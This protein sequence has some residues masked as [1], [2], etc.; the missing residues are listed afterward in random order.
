MDASIT[1]FVLNL[2]LDIV[3]GVGRL[4]LKGDG[5]AGQ[6]LYKDLHVAC[7]TKSTMTTSRAA[8]K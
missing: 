6:G 1:L 2:A 3:D 5:L 4:H 7:S 8:I